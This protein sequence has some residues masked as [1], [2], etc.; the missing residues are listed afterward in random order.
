MISTLTSFSVPSQ[1]VTGVAAGG[2]LVFLIMIHLLDD[3]PSLKI[4]ASYFRLFSAPL[5]VFLG[6]S[7]I[8]YVF[9]VLSS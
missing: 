4:T 9:H 8:S 2:L 6:F 1:L 3:S 7:V 5:L